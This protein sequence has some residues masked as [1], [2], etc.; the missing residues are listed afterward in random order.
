M[1]LQQA[2][3]LTSV[4]ALTP[5][6]ENPRVGDVDAIAESINVHGFYGAVVAQR[7]TGHVIAGN[8]RLLAARKQGLPELPVAWV[9]VSDEEA[10]RILLAD[11]RTSDLGDYDN[12][13][14][15]QLL[16]DLL[17]NTE[18]KLAGTGYDEAD[19][20]ALSEEP[21]VD[22]ST[23]TDSVQYEPSGECPEVSE[24]VDSTK[25]ET[26]LNQIAEAE[27]PDEVRDFLVAAAQRHLV[28]DYAK[29]AEFYAHADEDLQRLME[30][31]ALVVV[32]LD[33][34]IWHGFVRVTNRLSEIL[35][36]DLKDR[37]NYDAGERGWTE[38]A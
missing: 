38:D 13:Q 34:A 21:R 2:F 18:A 37:E 14:L 35:D 27:L 29:V 28:F 10:R 3:E 30:A 26:L 1:L 15:V 4:D 33:D 8:H 32:D 12:E 6:P 24:L 19:L 23:R 20:A 22:Y 31:S 17:E 25:T 9:D 36:L 5:H 16:T 7:S 11:N